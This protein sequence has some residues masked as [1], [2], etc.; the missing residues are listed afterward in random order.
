M[1]KKK[2][3]KKTSFSSNIL[4][5]QFISSLF[6]LLTPPIFFSL[7]VPPGS[8]PQ[9]VSGRD[10]ASRSENHRKRIPISIYQS[11]REFRVTSPLNFTS[12]SLLL[13]A[14][15]CD[16]QARNRHVLGHSLVYFVCLFAC[17]FV[18]LFVCLFLQRVC[19]FHTIV[20]FVC[21]LSPVVSPCATT[22]V[23]DSQLNSKEIHLQRKKSL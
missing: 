22:H 9:K 12:L 23:Y 3:R 7:G 6:F 20:C 2:K 13:R 21:L 19:F 4:F 16:E 1:R 11:G 15:E 18:C 8:C 10:N 14:A 17:L 5:L